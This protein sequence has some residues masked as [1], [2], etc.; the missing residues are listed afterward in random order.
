MHGVQ[1]SCTYQEAGISLA[2]PHN[3]IAFALISQ[4]ISN[5]S[6][7]ITSL[8]DRQN[9]TD[10]C[11]LIVRCLGLNNPVDIPHWAFIVNCYQ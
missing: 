5:D 3:A 7:L 11:F 1:N 8:R 6:L 10:A 2:L 9:K 4:L